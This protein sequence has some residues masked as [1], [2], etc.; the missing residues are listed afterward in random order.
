M[1]NLGEPEKELFSVNHG[2]TS[3]LHTL[4]GRGHYIAPHRLQSNSTAI[5]RP[6]LN[7]V[8]WKILFIL[9][10][11]LCFVLSVIALELWMTLTRCSSTARM[12]VVV[13]SFQRTG[14]EE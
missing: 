6:R 14:D 8:M 2:F 13:L 7:A 4:I 12:L 10:T 9:Q 5:G 1:T 3:A 11:R